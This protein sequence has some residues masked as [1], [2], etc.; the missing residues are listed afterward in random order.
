[1]RF[2]TRCFLSAGALAVAAFLL[3]PTSTSAQARVGQVIRVDEAADLVCLRGVGVQLLPDAVPVT[4]ADGSESTFANVLPADLLGHSVRIDL[5]AG[6]EDLTASSI[7][8]LE[9]NTDISVSGTG[10]IA[11]QVSEVNT[12][13]RSILLREVCFRLTDLTTTRDGEDVLTALDLS[14]GDLVSIAVGQP[15]SGGSRNTADTIT[16]V[17]TTPAPRTGRFVSFDETSGLLCLDGV[18]IH[19]ANASIPVTDSDDPDGASSTIQSALD[20]GTLIGARVSVTL[21]EGEETPTAG[22]LRIESDVAESGL[23]VLVGVV[24]TV[25]LTDLTMELN[26]VCVDLTDATVFSGTGVDGLEDLVEGQLVDVIVGLPVPGVPRVTADVVTVVGPPP[27]VRVGRVVSVDSEE[28]ILCLDNVV[29]RMGSSLRILDETEEVDATDTG[30]TSKVVG[31]RVAVELTASGDAYFATRIR[32]TDIDESDATTIVGDVTSASLSRGEIVLSNVCISLVDTDAFDAG[33]QFEVGDI[34]QVQVGVAAAGGTLP[35]AVTVV[36]PPASGPGPS[37]LVGP[38][39]FDLDL[40]AGDQRS[41][42]TSAAVAP[43]DEVAVDVF[44]TSGADL[45]T[46]FSVVFE[47][48]PGELTFTSFTA[49]DVF[50]GATVTTSVED[51]RVTV[52]ATVDQATMK[53]QGSLGQVRFTAGDDFEGGTT[54]RIVQAVTT[55]DSGDNELEIGSG[56]SFVVIGQAASAKTPDFDGSGTVDFR[57]FLMFSESF[58]TSSDDEAFDSRFDLDNDGQI[59]FTDFV[60]FAAAFGAPPSKPAT[61]V[62][63]GF[64]ASG[65]VVNGVSEGGRLVLTVDLDRPAGYSAYSLQLD[66]DPAVLRPSRVLS[67][68]PSRLTSGAPGLITNTEDGRTTVVDAVHATGNTPLLRAEFEVL[69]DRVTPTVRVTEV[70]VADRSRGV[71]ALGGA[72]WAAGPTAFRLHANYPN[73]FNPETQI[74]FDLPEASVVR[75]TVYNA[76]GQAVRTLAT[77]AFAAGTHTVAWDGKDSA[78]RSVSSGTYV[79]RIEAGA[80]RDV[81]KMVLVK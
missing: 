46:G 34:V 32:T 6:E 63:S 80:F 38:V 71:H 25:S 65:V 76:L 10:Q 43:G 21:V 57:D 52:T 5:V 62:S 50:L 79:Y 29:L 8:I 69:D 20:A 64:D 1:M 30:L 67:G 13:N 66:Y 14:E 68:S 77:D 41:R 54:V 12:E 59:G 55:D 31:K 16:R 19:I 35:R 2:L 47:Y 3:Q 4:F 51:G 23:G 18:S 26:Q 75:L 39:G 53:A 42:T 49:S 24:R 72:S 40:S 70:L 37:G 15:V 33:G 17:R 9:D 73:P 28:N 74:R 58:G 60:E 27:P 36:A 44:I 56:A 78:G 7:T 45:K 61:T 48:D 11:G 22:A 81:K